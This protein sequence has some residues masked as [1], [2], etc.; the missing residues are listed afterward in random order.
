MNKH[1]SHEQ[2]SALVVEFGLGGLPRDVV[3][4][5]RPALGHGASINQTHEAARALAEECPPT[6]LQGVFFALLVLSNPGV[7]LGGAGQTTTTGDK[8]G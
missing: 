1:E 5:V 2:A 4:R 3:D 6:C 8:N 7:Q